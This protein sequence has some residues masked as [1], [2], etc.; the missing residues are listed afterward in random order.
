MTFFEQWLSNIDAPIFSNIGMSTNISILVLVIYTKG[1]KFLDTLY[2]FMCIIEKPLEMPYWNLSCLQRI[3][4]LVYISSVSKNKI[5]KPYTQKF[6]RSK[7][8]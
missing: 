6:G 8:W 1:H 7:D 2:H 4:Q 3:G 5:T